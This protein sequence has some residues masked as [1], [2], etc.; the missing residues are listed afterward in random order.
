MTAVFSWTMAGWDDAVRFLLINHVLFM[1]EI[2]GDPSVEQTAEAVAYKSVAEAREIAVVQTRAAE[3]G[4][5]I[6]DGPVRLSRTEADPDT[7]AAAYEDRQPVY[8]VLLEIINDAMD[9]MDVS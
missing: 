8:P 3:E 9:G 2:D 1:I 6:L 4:D 7:L 5:Y